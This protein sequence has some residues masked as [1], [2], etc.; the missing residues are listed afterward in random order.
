MRL[1]LSIVR[2]QYSM[3]CIQSSSGD[4]TPPAVSFLEHAK[5]QAGCGQVGVFHGDIHYRT[6]L[7]AVLPGDFRG[8]WVTHDRVECS[9]QNREAQKKARHPMGGTPFW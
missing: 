4:C 3:A 2:F 9:K 6:H 7:L 1:A 5:P 8:L